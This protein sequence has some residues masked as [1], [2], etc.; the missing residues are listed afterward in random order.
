MFAAL[1]DGERDPEVL[2]ELA[3]GKLRAK[4]PQ[5]RQA[6]VGRVHRITSC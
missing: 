5:L 2:A 6:L 3:R 4:L 1:L